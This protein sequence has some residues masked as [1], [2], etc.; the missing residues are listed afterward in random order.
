MGAAFISCGNTRPD[1]PTK[2]LMP[3]SF[4][5]ARKAAGP[6]AVKAGVNHSSASR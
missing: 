5:Q 4:A 1:V 6:K 3:K 2:V